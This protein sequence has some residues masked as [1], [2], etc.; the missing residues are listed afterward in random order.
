MNG[1]SCRMTSNEIKLEKGHFIMLKLNV[2][3]N[4]LYILGSLNTDRLDKADNNR[5]QEIWCN[6]RQAA[7]F[8]CKHN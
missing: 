5:S 1:F 3:R 2:C 6:L 7:Y 4:L 8:I